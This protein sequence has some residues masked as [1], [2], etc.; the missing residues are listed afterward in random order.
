MSNISTSGAAKL[1]SHKKNPDIQINRDT[2]EIYLGHYKSAIEFSKKDTF[3]FVVARTSFVLSIFFTS[4]F[5]NFTFI[6]ARYLQLI[7]IFLAAIYVLSEF[8]KLFQ[9]DDSKFKK[10]NPEEMAKIIE[11]NCSKK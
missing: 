6:D 5:R 8:R 9:K 11:E 2:L 1:V 7:Y 3:L 4:N 10:T